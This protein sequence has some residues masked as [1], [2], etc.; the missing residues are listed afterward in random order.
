MYPPSVIPYASAALVALKQLRR[1]TRH[2]GH[3][4]TVR[5]IAEPA[6]LISIGTV[7]E[8]EPNRATA[9]RLA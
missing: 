8:D 4:L 3:D 5:T 6:R 7:I 9:K 1:E 2:R